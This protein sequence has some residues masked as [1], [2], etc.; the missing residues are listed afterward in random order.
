MFLE[1]VPGWDRTVSV[2]SCGDVNTADGE[3]EDILLLNPRIHRRQGLLAPP[4]LAVRS[5][6]ALLPPL[7]CIQVHMS[8]TLVTQASVT[9]PVQPEQL[10]WLE[11]WHA[12]GASGQVPSIDLHVLPY[13]LEKHPLGTES[14]STH[15]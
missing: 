5:A 15:A 12:R 10:D 1:H 3:P 7:L 4:A 13:L 6:L 2:E 8:L 14:P 9:L 11:T